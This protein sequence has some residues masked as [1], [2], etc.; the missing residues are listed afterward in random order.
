MI[1]YHDFTI[2]G[3]PFRL[4]DTFGVDYLG[5]IT[6]TSSILVKDTCH[7]SIFELISSVK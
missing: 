7:H 6:S 3:N 1:V 2:M 4:D 5:S